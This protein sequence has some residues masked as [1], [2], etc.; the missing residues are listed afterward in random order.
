M[1]M[2]VRVR[3]Y[4]RVLQNLLLHAWHAIAIVVVINAMLPLSIQ[5]AELRENIGDDDPHTVEEAVVWPVVSVYSSSSKQK[6]ADIALSSTLEDLISESKVVG[7]WRLVRF[8]KP[9]VPLWVSADYMQREGK[10][11]RVN[12]SRL[13]AR[14]APNLGARVIGRLLAGTSV[15]IIG[16]ENGFLKFLAPGEWQF[17]LRV[18][19]EKAVLQSITSNQIAPSQIT[20]AD[21]TEHRLAPGDT[22]SLKVFGESELSAAAVRIPASG[23]V[24]FPLIGSTQV[25]GLSV[26]QVEQAVATKLAQGYVRNPKLSVTIDAY[27]PIFIRGAVV[28]TG[29]FPFTEGLT[30]AKAIALAGGAKNSAKPDGITIT[31]DGA[32]VQS[33]LSS[34]SDYE[35][36]SGDVITLVEE[37]GVSEASTSYIYLHGEVKNP[38][39]YEYRRGL[40]VE[41]AVVLAGG[42]TLRASKRKI[43]VARTV[44]GQ[45]Q[46]ERLKKVKLH[47]AVQPG[48]IIRVGASWL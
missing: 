12:A 26:K 10:V 38:G 3:R 30:I 42:F 29:A 15:D 5:A 21:V 23:R 22:I 17:A 4:F 35:V 43:S 7:D 13:N 39:E 33:G 24:S 16:E 37:F 9:V 31:R 20:V 32:I 36:A 44:D 14:I 8:L 47:L 6:I 1:I 2:L 28:E 19:A 40:T 48:D 34:D 41:K 18:D 25:A 45:E 27:R 11:A 46:P